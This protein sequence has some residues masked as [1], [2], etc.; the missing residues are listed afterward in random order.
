MQKI[1]KRA[2]TWAKRCVKLG[3]Q[4]SQVARDRVY[5]IAWCH[6]LEW[7]RKKLFAQLQKAKMELKKLRAERRRRS[8]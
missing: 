3:T 6:E 4:G 5:L 1:R 7:S 2:A 8:A